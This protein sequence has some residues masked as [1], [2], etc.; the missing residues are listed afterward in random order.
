L[1]KKKARFPLLFREPGLL[2]L[3]LQSGEESTIMNALA[4]EIGGNTR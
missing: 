2:K 3:V 4:K 1:G